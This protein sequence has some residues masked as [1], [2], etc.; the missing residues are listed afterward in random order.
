[1]VEYAYVSPMGVSGPSPSAT[2]TIAAGQ[3]IQVG[4]IAAPATNFV[5]VTLSVPRLEDWHV[6]R[7]AV[8]M[9]SQVSMPSVYLYIDSVTPI[10]LLDTSAL[11]AQNSA[12]ADLYLRPGQILICQW[13]AA[14]IGATAVLSVF[15]E[16]TS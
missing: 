9:S 2:I 12:N 3:D 10:N 13:T 7:Y 1:M 16:K 8:L 6:T 15:G 5:Q 14:D 4:P 11:G